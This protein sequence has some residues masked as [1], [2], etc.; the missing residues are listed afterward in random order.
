MDWQERNARADGEWLGQRT[1]QRYRLP[2]GTEW[3]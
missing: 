2:S 3:D 1:G